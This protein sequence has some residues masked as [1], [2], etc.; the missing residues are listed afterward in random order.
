[1][2]AL[3]PRSEFNA[4]RSVIKKLVLQSDKVVKKRIFRVR[5]S[6][7]PLIIVRLD[8]AESI[9]RRDLVGVSLKKVAVE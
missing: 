2:E 9:M 1:M 4:D 3:S 5:E 6:E 8:V 7:K